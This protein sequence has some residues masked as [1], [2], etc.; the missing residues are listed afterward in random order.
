MTIIKYCSTLQKD[1]FKYGCLQGTVTLYATLLFNA[2]TINLVEHLV[3]YVED[4]GM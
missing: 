4:N 2:V 1:L 3:L